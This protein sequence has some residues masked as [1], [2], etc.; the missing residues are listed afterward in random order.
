MGLLSEA[1]VIREKLQG[2]ESLL[3]A[4]TLQLIG[5]A[6]LHTDANADARLYFQGAL[7]IREQLAPGRS[8]QPASSQFGVGVAYF[9]LGELAKAMTALRKAY[10]IRERL[11]GQSHGLSADALHQ[12]GLVYRALG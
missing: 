5:Q 8:A 11:F 12:L 3:Y 7:K 6:H 2:K 9:R 1:V 10:V 4:A